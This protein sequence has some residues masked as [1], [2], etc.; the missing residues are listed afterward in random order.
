LGE[1][2]D[3]CLRQDGRKQPKRKNSSPAFHGAKV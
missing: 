3:W 2:W 1:G